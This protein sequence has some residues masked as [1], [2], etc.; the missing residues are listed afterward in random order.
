MRRKY[1]RSNSK[2]KKVLKEILKY[3]SLLILAGFFVGLTTFVYYAKDLPRPEQFEESIFPETTKI[4]DRTGEHLLYKLH[5]EHQRTIVPL[6]AIPEPMEQAV[7]AAEDSH[8]YEHRGVDPE[9]ILRAVWKD[10]KLRELRY[11]GSTITQQLIRST[12]LTNKKTIK[13]KVREVILALELDRRH[14]KEQILEWYLNQVPFGG[15]AYGVEAAA[16]VY[17]DKSASNLELR[18]S[19]TLAALIK[20]PSY[21]SPYGQHKQ[22]LLNRKDYILDRMA[23]E[24]FITKKRAEQAKEKEIVFTDPSQFI[25]APHFVM[26]LLEYY[27]KPKYGSEFLK[28][29]GLKVYT[30]LDWELQKEAQQAVEE[31]TERV[32]KFDAHNG[33]AIAIKPET[34]EILAMVGSEDYYDVKQEGK[35]NV[36]I[37]PQQPGSAFKPFAYITAFNKGYTPTTTVMDTKTNFGTWGGEDFVPQNYDKRF[38]GKVTLKEALAQSINVPSTKVY[39]YLAGMKDTIKT[40]HEMGIKSDLPAVPSLVLGAG[41]VKLLNITSAYATL[42]NDG[43]RVPPTPIKR[44]ENSSGEVIE[45]NTPQ[46]KRVLKGKVVEMITDV[47]SDNEARAP[48]F[49]ENSIVSYEDRQVAVKTGTTDDY[50]DAWTVGY[51]D[52]VAVGVWVGN[53]DNS[54][55]KKRLGMLFSSPMWRKIMDAGIK[56]LE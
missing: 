26:Y 21:L 12:F 14:S 13:R 19:A 17:F 36:A 50:R 16:R 3:L 51:S 48:L 27:L 9:G 45:K 18:E 2:I 30:S 49:G 34:G 39:M 4:Y 31:N 32:E 35:V 29:E 40:A 54:P 20:A 46:G 53:N 10:I 42:A 11:G 38:R 25:K 44:I 15:N 8:F 6:E 1:H 7:V 28:K 23:Q 41:D 33:A 47:L 24:H 55:M 43:L 5:G 56:K 37:R 22:E 52:E